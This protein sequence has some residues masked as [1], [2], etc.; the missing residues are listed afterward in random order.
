MAA[1]A[2]RGAPRAPPR[3]ARPRAAR[4]RARPRPTLSA[5]RHRASRWKGFM[6]VMSDQ[7]SS[8]SYC[9]E[10]KCL[11]LLLACAFFGENLLYVKGAKLPKLPKKLLNK[12]PTFDLVERSW[13]AREKAGD[14]T[15]GRALEFFELSRSWAS[16]PWDA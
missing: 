14:L 11:T 15:N 5:V 3:A 7:T 2:P 6:L 13:I 12:D 10:T 8:M 1:S 16:V 9:M 4:P